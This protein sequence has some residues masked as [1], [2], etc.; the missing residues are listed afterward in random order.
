MASI[1][2]LKSQAAAWYTNIQPNSGKEQG[3]QIA[4]P[5]NVPGWMPRGTSVDFGSNL[6]RFLA[7]EVGHPCTGVNNYMMGAFTDHGCSGLM[8]PTSPYYNAWVGCYVI[9]DDTRV[10]H[11]GFRDDGSPIMDVLAAVAKSDQRIML[12]GTNCP[13]PFRFDLVDVQLGHVQ[14]P[15]GDWVEFKSVIETWSLFHQGRRAGASGK[16][17]ISFGSPP[18]SATFDV[19]EFHPIT[20]LGTMLARHDFKLK[21]TFCKFCNSAR[22]TDNTGKLHSTEELIGEEQRDMLTRTAVHG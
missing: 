19:G 8:D 9:F 11:Y 15:D 5:R 22:W 17:Y 18:P 21:A 6:G 16:Y 10:A 2:Q 3:V 4:L 20:Y 7:D 13:H 14:E 1:N 12:T